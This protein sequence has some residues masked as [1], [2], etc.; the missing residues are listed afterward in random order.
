MA[1]YLQASKH[2]TPL[3]KN[4][5]IWANNKVK[6]SGYKDWQSAFRDLFYGGVESGIV[7]HL[8]YSVDCQKFVKKY[9]IEIIEVIAEYENET[10]EPFFAKRNISIDLLAWAGFELA[11]RKIADQNDYDY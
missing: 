9:L 4:V 6:E 10:G 8:I 5:R 1:K 3:E 2:E 7:N 11:A